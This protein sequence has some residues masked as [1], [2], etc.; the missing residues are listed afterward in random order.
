MFSR[1]N[2]RSIGAVLCWLGCFVSTFL[3]M[4]MALLDIRAIRKSWIEQ[5]RNLVA[6]SLSD[7]ATAKKN[8]VAKNPERK[9][10]DRADAEREHLENGIAP[11]PESDRA[12][13]D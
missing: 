12:D 2:Y 10:L 4:L 5:H 3:A 6:T 7:I 8:R 1:T 13:N 11:S 9:K